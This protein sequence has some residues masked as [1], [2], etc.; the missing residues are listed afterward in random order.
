MSAKD[1]AGCDMAVV[2][3]AVN[4]LRTQQQVFDFGFQYRVDSGLGGLYAFWLSGGACLYVGMTIDIRRR[5]GEHRTDT[6]NSHLQQ[7]FSAFYGEIMVSYVALPGYSEAELKAME[8]KAKGKL[9]PFNN[10]A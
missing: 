3:C 7:Y 2:C 8:D 6:H 9:R 4:V 5:M 10:V 1:F